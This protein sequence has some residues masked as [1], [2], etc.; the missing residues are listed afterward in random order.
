M[1]FWVPSTGQYSSKILVFQFHK[2]GKIRVKVIYVDYFL[3]LKTYQHVILLSD[4]TLRSGCFCVRFLWISFFSRNAIS[5]RLTVLICQ[6]FTLITRLE[7][8]KI[9]MLKIYGRC[10]KPNKLYV[11][12]W[13]TKFAILSS[14][15][16]FMTTRQN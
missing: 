7:F 15:D 14:S 16:F 13:E 9:V 2:N 4:K 6:Q 3:P 8:T 5:A 1:S 10:F 12:S 11:E